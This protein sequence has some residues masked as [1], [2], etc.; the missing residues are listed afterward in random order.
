[1]TLRFVC[2]TLYWVSYFHSSNGVGVQGTQ[3]YPGALGHAE[4]LTW[5]KTAL[6]EDPVLNDW[7]EP[8]CEIS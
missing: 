2:Q 4:R 6:P 8:Y 3:W 1:M 7:C 5:H